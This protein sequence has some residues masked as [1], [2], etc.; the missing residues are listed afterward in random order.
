M[1]QSGDPSLDF[2][3]QRLVS[4]LAPTLSCADRIPASMTLRR[5]F[6]S[7]RIEMNDRCSSWDCSEGDVTGELD[8][9]LI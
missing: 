3:R 1:P 5:C 4:G 2:L 8:L 6:E 7:I 9:Q